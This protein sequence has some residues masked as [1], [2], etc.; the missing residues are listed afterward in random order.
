MDKADFFLRAAAGKPLSLIIQK[1]GLTSRQTGI[2]ALYVSHQHIQQLA[3]FTVLHADRIPVVGRF[4]G[5]C[6]GLPARDVGITALRADTVL[7]YHALINDLLV[8]PVSLSLI[9]V[10][11]LIFMPAHH[12]LSVCRVDLSRRFERHSGI[13]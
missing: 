7:D 8:L 3:G 12:C 9:A 2:I 10:D 1:V 13:V 4:S 11:M 6:C 5:N